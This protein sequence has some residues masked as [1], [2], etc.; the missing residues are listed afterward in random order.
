[1]PEEKD[2]KIVT[3]EDWK[4]QAHH[5]KEK[6]AEEAK[7]APA[8]AEPGPPTGPLPSP[9]FLTLLNSLLLQTMYCLGRI[10]GPNDD[11]PPQLN[12]DL[13]KHHI[14][15]IEILDEKTKGNLTEEET[16]ALAMAV[17]EARMAY[18]AAAQS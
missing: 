18:V 14:G 13:A 4:S 17:H 16:K 1:M 2:S 11:E 8:P 9:N 15:M 3:D 6:L 5:E 12:L 7:S 10:A